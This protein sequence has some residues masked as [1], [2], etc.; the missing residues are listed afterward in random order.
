[1]PTTT[2]AT[3]TTIGE[4][5]SGYTYIPIDPT[6]VHIEPGICSLGYSDIGD[7]PKQ[8]KLLDMLPDNAVRMSMEI[9]DSRGSV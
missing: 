8:T 1:M 6:K 2:Q 4:I 9:S 7:G 5:T 3:A